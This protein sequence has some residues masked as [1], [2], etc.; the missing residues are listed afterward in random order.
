VADRRR[1][2]RAWKVNGRG[3]W[4]NSPEDLA[5]VARKLQALPGRTA[6]EDPVTKERYLPLREFAELTGMPE[7]QISYHRRKPYVGPLGR[8]IKFTRAPWPARRNSCAKVYLD[9]EEDA[10]RIADWKRAG[11]GGPG[12][13]GAGS[14]SSRP[15]PG[16]ESRT[17]GGGQ[18]REP[19]PR[20]AHPVYLV[21]P[22]SG[23]PPYQQ[24]IAPA[25]GRAVEPP[26]ASMPAQKDRR[27]ALNDTEQNIIEWV[28][29]AACAYLTIC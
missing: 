4:R 19:L 6:Y 21:P 13:P 7:Q 1:P 24:P 11:S 12:A 16:A 29:D 27:P 2:L 25:G 5:E 26:Q 20:A 28:R 10:Y 8:C 17:R 3:P 14:A 18:A 15:Q 23:Q 9:S 22:P